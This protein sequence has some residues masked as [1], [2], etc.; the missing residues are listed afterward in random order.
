[1]FGADDRRLGDGEN[2]HLVG[3]AGEIG[4]GA[5]LNAVEMLLAADMDLGGKPSPDNGFPD[6]IFAVF[7]S[8]SKDYTVCPISC[9][10]APARAA[11]GILFAFGFSYLL[12]LYHASPKARNQ[13]H[14]NIPA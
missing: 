8:H 3:K 6:N 7:I 14:S 1:V 10:S 9:Q 11:A 13:L 12:N 2:R 5:K 4:A